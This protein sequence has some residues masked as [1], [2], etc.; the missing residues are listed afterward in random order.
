MD[1]EQAR[2][3]LVIVARGSFL[4][5]AK[6]LHVTQST[7]SARVQSLENAL[8]ASLFNRHRDGVTLTSAGRRFLR[9][10][11]TMVRAHEQACH[12]VGSQQPFVATWRI[13]GRIALWDTYLCSWIRWIEQS[14]PP[15]SVQ[16]EIGF[17]DDL[18]RRLIDESLDIAFL[19][20]PT[21]SPGLIVEHVF[22]ETLVPVSSTPDSALTD[23]GYVHVDWGA[24]FFNQY[25]ASFPDAAPSTLT[26]NIGWL[27][28]Q[29]LLTRGGSCYLPKRLARPFIDSDTL[30]LVHQAPI[31]TLP[32][33]MVS[34][35]TLSSELLE[36]ALQGARDIASELLDH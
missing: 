8:G 12:D 20:T 17:E 10:A 27:A 34:H 29:L 14:L 30:F 5:A 26:A 23:P 7:V 32:A 36:Q 28:I 15:V 21:H 11:R 2:T 13:G 19:Y 9:H 22:D 16:C 6:H 24:A 25:H 3:F 1:I 33:Y 18:M 35:R 31:F 4:E